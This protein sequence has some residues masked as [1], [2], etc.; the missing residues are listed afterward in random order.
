MLID[1]TVHE[2][3]RGLI[4]ENFSRDDANAILRIPLSR[5]DVPDKIVW[6]PNKD[7]LYS[8][9]SEYYIVGLLAKEINGMEGS[10]D[11]QNRGLIWTRLWKF[12]L[13]NK[14]KLFGWRACHNILPTKENL[15]RRRITQ[16][17]VCEL[18]NQGPESGLHALWECGVARDVWAVNKGRFQKSVCGQ[19][20]FSHLFVNLMDRL[21]REELESFM[22]Q[23]WLI[24]NQRNSVLHGGMLQDPSRLIQ[25][26]ADLLD[27]F[28]EA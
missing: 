12:R 21:S 4:R 25:R 18:C 13:P 23:S 17:S 11:G 1:E 10:S 22:V 24:W 19:T 15:V 14:I 9:K 26:A 3:D 8:V 28:N 16:D 6:L 20:N 2:W 7:G 5:R 27:E